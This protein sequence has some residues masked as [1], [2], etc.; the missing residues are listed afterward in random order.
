M[1]INVLF[2]DVYL[3]DYDEKL[4]TR[5][6]I[7]DEFND[8]VTKLANEISNNNNLQ[9]FI[10]RDPNTQVISLV[11]DSTQRLINSDTEE[12]AD[13]MRSIAQRLLEKEIDKQD[14]ISHMGINVKKGSL[15]QAILL[16]NDGLETE[17]LYMLTKVE[18]NDFFDEESYNIK[19]GFPVDRINLWKSCLIHLS[20]ENER[21]SIG[22]IKVFLDNPANY[23]HND[24]LEINPLRKDDENT[25]KLFRAVDK[26]LH[27]KIFDESNHEY[28]MLRNNLI[29]YLRRT[30]QLDYSDLVTTLFRDY[31]YEELSPKTKKEVIDA[32]NELPEK[33]SFDRKFICIHSAI[34]AR[35]IKKTYDLTEDI[36]LVIKK[37]LENVDIVS[38]GEDSGKK[39]VKIYTENREVYNTFRIIK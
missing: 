17:Y 5:K 12:I 34:K 4:S 14:Q 21:V 31:D 7:T 20:I 29:G 6:P 33:C 25:K 26:V 1:S 13:N 24:F 27:S 39:Y 16:S 38:S 37:D 19:R 22:E 11:L 30:E 23:W 36:D 3:I 15:L 32:L 35:I 2:K 28:F 9:Y 8:Y 18:H 10:I